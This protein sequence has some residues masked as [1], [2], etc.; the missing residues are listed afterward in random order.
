[1]KDATPLNEGIAAC[2]AASLE[3]FPPL[4]GE[5]TADYLVR[6]AKADA[7]IF[8]AIARA[9]SCHDL[10][11]LDDDELGRVAQRFAQ[12]IAGELELVKRANARFEARPVPAVRRAA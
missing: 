6:C 1:V 11:Q 12:V 10:G 8:H 9:V 2:R 3:A 4:E 5:T 7:V